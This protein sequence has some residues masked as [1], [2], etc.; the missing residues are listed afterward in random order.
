MIIPESLW[1][2]QPPVKAT[3][4]LVNL[5]MHTTYSD[6]S[7]PH[8]D[9][10]AAALRAGLDAIIVTDHNVRVT[11]LDA[12]HENGAHRVLVLVGEEIHDQSRQPQKNHL[13]VIGANRELAMYAE[14]P[15][16]LI[17]QVQLAGGMSF[18]AHPIDPALP[19]FGEDDISW[20]N[21]DVQG[22]TGIELW[23]GFSEFKT[24]VH[25]IPSAVFHVFFPQ[26]IAHGPIPN[27]LKRWDSLLQKGKKIVA[28]GGSDAHA[29]KKKAGP[30]RK[31]I[32]PY[33]FH[34]RAINTH[35]L[36][37]EPL[38]GNVL[39]DRKSIYTA[40]RQGHAFIGYD[41]PAPTR[42]FRFTAQGNDVSAM[43]GDDMPL[44]TGATLQ[45]RLPSKAEILL[46]KDGQI[47]KRWSE[48][49]HALVMVNQPGIYRVECYTHYWGARRGW[50]FSNPIYIYEGKRNGNQ[51]RNQAAGFTQDSLPGF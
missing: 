32:F 43:M 14:N 26:L 50:I 49:D 40:I 9:L 24:V 13:L 28:V 23:N 46:V 25:S 34:F 15:Q 27:T 4:I 7:A 2:R 20:E 33:E 11:G 37:P 10:A 8:A 51:Q 5:H 36:L 22:F 29:L 16:N 1:N 3:E 17:N 47:F 39:S 42:G 6:G 35:L 19:A 18:I 38:T 12:Y 21:W 45:I 30:L 44:S 31:T 41:I 48:T